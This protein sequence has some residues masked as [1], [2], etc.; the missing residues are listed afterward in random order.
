[1]RPVPPDR[2]LGA[3]RGRGQRLLGYGK[4]LA[5]ELPDRG[6]QGLQGV[7]A[8]GV[9]GLP[10]GFLLPLSDLVAAERGLV[11]LVEE[12]RGDA[13]RLKVLGNR[14]LAVLVV[15]ADGCLQVGLNTNPY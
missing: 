7:V 14:V 8:P 2:P 6:L 13:D 9:G 1:M 15:F 10:G 11:A 12:L 4:A 5:Q 3:P